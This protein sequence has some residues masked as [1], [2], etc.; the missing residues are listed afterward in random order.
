MLT[1]TFKSEVSGR[2]SGRVGGR[3]GGRASV[4][5]LGGCVV[6]AWWMRVVT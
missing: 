4:R 5:V 3:V 1:V 6:G 2:V